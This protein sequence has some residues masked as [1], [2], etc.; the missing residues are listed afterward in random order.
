MGIAPSDAS[1]EVVDLAGDAAETL[2]VDLDLPRLNGLGG[3]SVSEEGSESDP[4]LVGATAS[5][6]KEG[7]MEDPL[8]GTA[9][10]SGWEVTTGRG[11][12]EAVSNKWGRSAVPSV[13]GIAI[14]ETL[15]KS[16][17]SNRKSKQN[18]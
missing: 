7:G 1:E 17:K 9:A 2:G 4:C 13:E 8:A 3:F 5:T 18:Y 15:S 12:K 6:L 16:M 10:E 11:A 14:F